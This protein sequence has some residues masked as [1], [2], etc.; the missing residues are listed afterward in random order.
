MHTTVSYDGHNTGT[1]MALAAREAGLKEICFTDHL[2]YDPRGLMKMDFHTES[3]NAAYDALE[4]P[5]LTIRRGAE[6]GMLRDN[7]E[8]LKK[9]LQRRHFD[10]IIGSCHFTEDLDIYFP[11]FWVGKTME[12]AETLY[13]E[14]V[15]AC[16]QA[17][18]DFDVLGHLTYISKAASNPTHRKV[19]YE[20][21]RE[22]VDEILRTLARKGK[23]MEVNTSGMTRCGVFLPE[24]VYLRRFKELGGEIVTVGS[25]AHDVKRV[26]E[27]CMTAARQVADIFG[28]VCTFADRKPVFHSKKTL[29]KGL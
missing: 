5:G 9:D 12:Q 15:L 6:F 25:D 3:Y 24:A 4:V 19:E 1:E 17:H 28:Y 20:R 29:E 11:P 10:F 13:L 8:Q 26:G 22:L 18:D 21:Y 7:P 16:V 14:E 23:G 2:D 27:N